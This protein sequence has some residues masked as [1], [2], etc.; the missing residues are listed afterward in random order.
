[1]D[2]INIVILSHCCH[3]QNH[4]KG[5][6]VTLAKLLLK[7]K[8]ISMP[9]CSPICRIELL[10]IYFVPLWAQLKTKPMYAQVR[11]ALME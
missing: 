3:F 9:L 6:Q 5:K 8:V 7:E 10:Q 11:T 4:A 1:M 2:S